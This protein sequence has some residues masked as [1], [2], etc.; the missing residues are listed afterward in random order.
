MSPPSP[1]SSHRRTVS[2][3]PD[4][5]SVLPSGE[6]ASER[7]IFFSP[8]I[9]RFSLPVSTSHSLMPAPVQPVA[10]VLP[11]LLQAEQVI[12]PLWP[13]LTSQP[14]GLTL[15]GFPSPREPDVPPPVV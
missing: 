15:H 3:L 14:G 1:S 6:K 10:S 12:S 13:S 11:S 4:D 5:A 2:S 9:S 7:I 8:F